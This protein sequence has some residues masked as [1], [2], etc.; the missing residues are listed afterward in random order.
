MR[1]AEKH[2]IGLPCKIRACYRAAIMPDQRKRAANC[3]RPNIPLAWHDGIN[4]AAQAGEA[5]RE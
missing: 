2:E 3:R 5:E 1:I 4:E